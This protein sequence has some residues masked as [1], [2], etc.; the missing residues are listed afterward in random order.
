MGRRP[1]SLSSKLRKR[2][3]TGFEWFVSRTAIWNRAPG[4]SILRG[5]WNGGLLFITPLQCFRHSW[6][7]WELSECVLVSCHFVPPC[8]KFYSSVHLL[9]CARYS[10][11]STLLSTFSW[12]LTSWCS[13]ES[14]ARIYKTKK[15]GA[16][17]LVHNT[18]VD[19]GPLWNRRRQMFNNSIWPVRVWNHLP[20]DL[21]V[22]RLSHLRSVHFSPEVLGGIYGRWK[23]TWKVTTGGPSKIYCDLY[24]DGPDA[25]SIGTLRLNVVHWDANRVE[26]EKA[27]HLNLMNAAL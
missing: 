8:R 13:V 9:L 20:V 5:K 14:E 24:R 7:A 11:S 4:P 6:V 16:I 3:E 2:V 12:E 27:G 21:S 19:S 26:E 22:S 25:E 15:R 17:L 10:P 23:R 1:C 18:L